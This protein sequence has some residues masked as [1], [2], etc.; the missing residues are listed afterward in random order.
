VA[1]I[2]LGVA[3]ASRHSAC[4]QDAGLVADG[5]QVEL[6]AGGFAFT[7]G[8]ACDR[9]GNVFFSDIP[10]NR[11]HRWSTD[12]VLTTFRA[13]SGGANGLAFDRHGN[14]LCCEGTARRLTSV[15]PD[16]RVEVLA[17]Q[18]NGKKLNSP[19]DLWIAP[20]G[21]VY[22]T[23]PRYG[24]M[25]D[26]QQGG[27]H[28]YYLSPDR[29]TLTRVIDDMVMPNG[30]IGTAD[31]ERLYVADLGDNKTYVYRV[32]GPGA[33]ADRRL[34]AAEGSDGMTLDERGNVYLTTSAVRVY[35][36]EGKSIATIAVPE[37]PA[38]VTFGGKDRRTL[39][40]TARTGFYAVP[41][42]VRG[43]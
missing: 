1:V 16:G 35:S 34:F 19:N 20:D 43:Q 8:P 31:G 9:D 26:L 12:G 42:N 15:S 14:L 23:D 10:N 6:L 29:K 24:S 13:G 41:M 30:I 18:Y 7:E 37:R 17:D 22:F 28:V 36:P 27:F 5:A 40:I 38:N 32:A 33:L 4:A 3:C 11:I 25:D 2:T 39:F 21:G